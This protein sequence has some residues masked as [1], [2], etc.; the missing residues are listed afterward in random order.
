MSSEPEISQFL[1][2][3]RALPGTSVAA[4]G[5]LRE[6][7]R[8]EA[9]VGARLPAAHRAL[10]LAANGMTASFGYQRLFGVGDGS[11]DIGP[12]NAHDTWKFAWPRQLDELLSIGQTGW[13]DQ[14]VYRLGDL[15][16]GRDVV[17][18]LDRFLMEVADEPL[19]GS[20]EALLSW[21][22]HQAHNLDD[23]VREARRQIGDLGPDQLAVFTPSPLLVGLERATALMKMDARIAMVTGG[24]LSAQLTDV[25]NETRR[26]DRIDTYLDEQ[27]RSRL[28]VV[29]VPLPSLPD[30]A[31]L[32]ASFVAEAPPR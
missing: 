14:F 18:W 31:P 19:A 7:E 30:E 11:Q 9:F 26:I 16:R 3:L 17:Y 25:D 28:R 2:E 32:G 20:F 5:R 12:W 29:W 1:D 8:V 24:D 22:S 27:G 15:R 4:A 6:V 21:L 13:G 10:L 23:G